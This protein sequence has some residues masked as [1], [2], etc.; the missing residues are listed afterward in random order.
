MVDEADGE[1]G[2]SG[3]SG[4]GEGDVVE[5]PAPPRSPSPGG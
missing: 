2:D 1:G 3:D 5:T 4:Y